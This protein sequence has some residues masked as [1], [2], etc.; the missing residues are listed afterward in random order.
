MVSS[1][2]QARVELQTKAGAAPKTKGVYRMLRFLF[3]GFFLI[4]CLATLNCQT[5]TT[6]L[7]QG[8]G[9]A[10]EVAALSTLGAIA[11][12]Q[13]AYSISNP[14]DYGTFEQLAAGGY[15]DD[16]FKNSKPKFYGYIF[17]MSVIPKSDAKDGSYTLNVDPDPALKVSGKHF[18]LDSNSADIHVN[19][20]Q[21]AGASD[22]IVK[23]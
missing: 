19:A 4:V 13:T 1:L 15:L 12:A 22:G 3:T 14:G 11:R 20:S 17:T 10:D 23:P 9:R 18:Y 2:E 6:G 8:A 16:R 21:Q 5:Y 7:Q